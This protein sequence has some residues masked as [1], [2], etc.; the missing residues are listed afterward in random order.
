MSKAVTVSSYDQLQELVKSNQLLMLY[1]YDKSSA[2]YAEETSVF[3][4]ISDNISAPNFITFVKV[5]IA[6]QNELAARYNVTKAPA[7]IYF[8]NGKEEARSQGGTSVANFMMKLRDDATKLIAARI[9]GS[10][11]GDASNW[12]GAELPRGYGNITSQIEKQRCEL[13]NVDSNTGGLKALFE[14]SKP[15]ALAGGKSLGYADWVES[16]TD[17]QLMLFMPFQSMLKLHTLQITSLPPQDD[18]DDDEVPMR[19]RKIKLFTNKPHNL[20]FDEAED[21]ASTQTLEL[22]EKDWNAEGTAT[23]PLRYVKFQNITSLVMFVVDG[24]GDGEK[25]RLDRIRLVGEAGEKREMGKLEK[26]G[27]GSE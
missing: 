5:D 3:N 18:D 27:E 11:T 17:E 6:A 25:V 21:M 7:F 14:A 12:M 24:D 26:I 20:G 23:V 22:S 16:D 9:G 2:S 15:S 1:V 8:L 10:G 4:S 19:P 13:L